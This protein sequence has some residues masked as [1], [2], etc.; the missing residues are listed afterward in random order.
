MGD[1]HGLPPEQVEELRRTA[2]CATV[3]PLTR[4]AILAS[5]ASSLP[6]AALLALAASL[7]APA[8]AADNPWLA[9]RVLN[10]AHQGGEDEFPSNTLY[11]FKRSVKAGADMLEL[12]VGVTKDGKVVVSHDTTLNRTTNGKGTIESRTLARSA[13]STG[14]SGSER[15]MTPTRTSAG[16]RPTS[17]V[18]SPPASA[19]RRGGYKRA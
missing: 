7:P 15:A 5:C 9:Q 19:G 10:I 18:A 1:G 17:C 14:R 8:A 11:A 2:G 6:I 16:G 3:L 12:D 4:A 13:G